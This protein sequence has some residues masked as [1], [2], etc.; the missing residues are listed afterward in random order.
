MTAYEKSRCKKLRELLHLE[1]SRALPERRGDDF[2]RWYECVVRVRA[3]QMLI[4][5]LPVERDR[6]EL[7]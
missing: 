7:A 5:D 4:H 6:K 2:D 3:L 1:L